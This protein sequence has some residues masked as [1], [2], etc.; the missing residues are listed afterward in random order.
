[1]KNKAVISIML[2]AVSQQVYCLSLN[3][4]LKEA[5]KKALQQSTTSP[6]A[7]NQQVSES[8]SQQVSEPQ[9]QQVSE[10]QHQQ[11][12]LCI[13]NICVGDA[14]GI[15][16]EIIDKAYYKSEKEVY[17]QNFTICEKERIDT[18]EKAK[19]TQKK[20]GRIKL[21]DYIIST[22]SNPQGCVD[23]ANKKKQSYSQAVN[24]DKATTL[25]FLKAWTS[26]SE[27]DA[28]N[29]ANTQPATLLDSN[30]YYGNNKLLGS[31][32]IS[33]KTNIGSFHVFESLPLVCQPIVI[34]GRMKNGD[35]SFF[36]L[37][38]QE[39]RKF[40]IISLGTKIENVSRVESSSLAEKYREKF[41]GYSIFETG[42]MELDPITPPQILYYKSAN[43]FGIT[44][45]HPLFR[46]MEHNHESMPNYLKNQ[47]L[48]ITPDVILSGGVSYEPENFLSKDYLKSSR[49]ESMVKTDIQIK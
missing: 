23:T 7:E 14:L 15:H 21:N 48:S 30:N 2:L 4:M 38:E 33:P 45:F 18:L 9:N 40:I 41:A 3:D 35:I 31:L 20:Y 17:D 36:A 16:D 32:L 27:K 28:E 12:K 26:L 13:S 6:T 1:M 44:M 34:Q 49:C 11:V 46:G 10:P 5:A 42:T 43:V 37:Q 19:E 24:N 29:I 8:Q 47:F 22:Y 39:S 25:S